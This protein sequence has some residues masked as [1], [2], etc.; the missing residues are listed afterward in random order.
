MPGNSSR[1]MSNTSAPLQGNAGASVARD[2]ARRNIWNL[3]DAGRAVVAGRC[4]S[5]LEVQGLVCRSVDTETV[6]LLRSLLTEIGQKHGAIATA[7][8]KLLD[9][10]FAGEIARVESIRDTADLQF[11][12]QQAVEAQE[13]TKTEHTTGMLWAIFTHLHCTASLMDKICADVLIMPQSIVAEPQKTDTVSPA[14]KHELGELRQKLLRQKLSFSKRLQS[15]RYEVVRL[16]NVTRLLRDQLTEAGAATNSADLLSREDSDR[17]QCMLRETSQLL[18]STREQLHEE[19]EHAREQLH[20]L[21]EQKLDNAKLEQLIDHLVGDD[22]EADAVCDQSL[23]GK[24][25]L[26]L[27]GKP[28][29]CKRFRAYVESNNGDFLHYD[30]DTEENDAEESSNQIDQLV[31][32][33]DAVFCPV[34]QTSHLAINRARKLCERSEKPMVFLPKTSLSAFVS[35]IR[36]IQ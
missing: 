25:V 16:E 2:R 7:A 32:R 14:I 23:S 35:G 9:E 15:Y 20:R 1:T 22:H 11:I 17:L 21:E 13:T 4:F 8:E 26:L 30:G 10:K 27:G 5:L 34:E 3:S 12:W 24:C 31:S 19:R 28:S 33:A 36:T 29:Q 18:R 6:V